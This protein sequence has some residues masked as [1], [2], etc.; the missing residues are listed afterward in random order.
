M[1]LAL[2]NWSWRKYGTKF[3]L[4]TVNLCM[5]GILVHVFSLLDDLI[6]KPCAIED[7][8]TRLGYILI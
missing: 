5:L 8:N 2:K 4:K 1:Q 7:K 6:V 3:S